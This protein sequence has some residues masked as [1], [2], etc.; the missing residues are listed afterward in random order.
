MSGIEVVSVVAALVGVVGNT[1]KVLHNVQKQYESDKYEKPTRETR[2]LLVTVS[3][4]RLSLSLL[5]TQRRLLT[6]SPAFAHTATADSMTQD[7][8]TTTRATVAMVVVMKERLGRAMIAAQSDQKFSLRLKTYLSGHNA[9]LGGHTDVLHEL[10]HTEL[11]PLV[12][13]WEDMIAIRYLRSYLLRG[14][15]L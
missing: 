10:L 14:S 5:E 4:A 15:S 2:A 9:E 1:I 8:F 7:L 11:I 6:T 3:L 13:K 12:Q